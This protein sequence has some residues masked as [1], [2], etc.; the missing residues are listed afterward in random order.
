MAPNEVTSGKVTQVEHYG[1]YI[2]T[3]EGPAL[4]LI[5]DVSKER[6]PDLAAAY[7]AGDSVRVKLLRFVPERGLFKATMILDD[8][9]Q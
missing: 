6:I 2:E 4:V 7:K 5:P 3:G 9:G 8:E 1:L